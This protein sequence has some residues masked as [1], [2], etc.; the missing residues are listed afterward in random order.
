MNG[1]RNMATMIGILSCSSILFALAFAVTR[2]DLQ[3]AKNAV[4][5]NEYGRTPS[6]ERMFREQTTQN[7]DLIHTTY[8]LQAAMIV[9]TQEIASTATTVKICVPD[10]VMHGEEGS[11]YRVEPNAPCKT[12]FNFAVVFTVTLVNGLPT[13]GNPTVNGKPVGTT[14]I[15]G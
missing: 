12:Q 5:I 1:S 9:R 4:T 11:P 6:E 7:D 15:Y 2:E 10:T 13:I 8:A 14:I 3:A